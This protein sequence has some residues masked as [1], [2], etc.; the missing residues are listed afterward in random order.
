M[1]KLYC[2]IAILCMSLLSA[3]AADVIIEKNYN[4]KDFRGLSISSTFEV[5][6]VQSDSYSVNIAVPAE[7]APYLDVR[8]TGGILN[9]G[10]KNLPRKLNAASIV[11]SAAVAKVSMPS[12]ERLSLSGASKFESEDAFN[13]GNAGFQISVSGASEVKRVEVYGADA[14]INVSGAARAN[15]AGSFIDVE[16]VASGTARVMLTADGEDLDVKTSGSAVADIEGLY[17]NFDFNTSGAANITVK[18]G[19]E[20]M[21]VECSGASSVDAL[22]AP[23][24]T[25]DVSLSGASV[26]KAYVSE[27]LEVKCSG[28]SSLSYKADGDI[29]LNIKEISRT[30]GLKKL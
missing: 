8:V 21:D 16:I 22:K 11:K 17:E 15:I 27:K 3:K 25:A 14:L 29:M 2:I 1:K 4:L 7:Y 10:F 9:I 20:D 6:A 5:T 23:V 30:A 24:R 13:I 28:A 19:A 12:L 26:C 18:G